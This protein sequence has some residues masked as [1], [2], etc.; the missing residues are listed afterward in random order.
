M[1]REVTVGHVGRETDRQSGKLQDSSGCGR[2]NVTLE[3]AQSQQA[4]EAWQ[5]ETAARE[6]QCPAPVR[7]PVRQELAEWV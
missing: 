3:R 7:L 6:W 5:A 2:A 1:E 4:V